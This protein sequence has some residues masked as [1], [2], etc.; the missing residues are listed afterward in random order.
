MLTRVLMQFRANRLVASFAR[1]TV[2]ENSDTADKLRK[3]GA[4]AVGPLVRALS[5]PDRVTQMEAVRA[6]GH[7]GSVDALRPLTAVTKNG[8]PELAGEAHRAIQRVLAKSDRRHADSEESI[9]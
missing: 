8:D 1:G 7:L 9:Q 4:P 3:I 2:R 5:D 6:L